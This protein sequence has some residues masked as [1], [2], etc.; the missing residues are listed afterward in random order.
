MYSSTLNLGFGDPS[1]SGD[2]SK[3]LFSFVIAFSIDSQPWSNS[4][5]VTISITAKAN[6]KHFV[7]PTTHS[8]SPASMVSKKMKKT[9]LLSLSPAHKKSQMGL[10]KV[11]SI[12]WNN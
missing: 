12:N 11:T 1:N 10:K 9:H 4:I 7:N 8:I 6:L 5:V 2:H 3:I